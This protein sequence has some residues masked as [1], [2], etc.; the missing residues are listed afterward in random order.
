MTG[1]DAI[2]IAAAA[3]CA[4]L[5]V[6]KDSQCRNGESCGKSQKL[7][8]VSFTEIHRWEVLIHPWLATKD[9]AKDPARAAKMTLASGP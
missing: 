9:H 3:Q 1:L 8:R 5:T 4:R 2:C 6:G 7:K